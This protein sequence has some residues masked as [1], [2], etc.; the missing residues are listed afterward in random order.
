MTKKK[1][2]YNGPT[3]E[4]YALSGSED[5]HQIALFMWAANPDNRIAYPELKWMFAIPNGGSRHKAEAG[6]FRAM[7]VKAGVLDILLPVKRG[8]WSGLFIEMKRPPK[9]GKR[10]GRI[11]SEQKLWRDFLLTQHYGVA[12]CV[13]WEAARNMILNYLNY[14]KEEDEK[15]GIQRDNQG[16]LQESNQAAV[17]GLTA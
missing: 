10:E 11:S 2:T 5:A 4:K 16:H 15:S 3:P 13:G 7:G 9:D 6:K 12:V 8:E 14:G 1:Y 17:S